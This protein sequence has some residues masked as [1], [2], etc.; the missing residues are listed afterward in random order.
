ME[1]SEKHISVRVYE[2]EKGRVVA[3]CDRELIG[4]MLREGEMRLEIKREFYFEKFV[5]SEELAELI[6][7]CFTAN[8]VGERTTSAYC[9]I[10]PDAR[11][12]I[13][14]VEGVPHM[15]IFLL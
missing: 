5:S 1:T 2:T 10:N 12:S 3:A 9:D 8:L 14:S 4:K 13:I 7:G 15:Q 6:E 11:R